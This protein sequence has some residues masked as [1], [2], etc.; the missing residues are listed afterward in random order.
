[1]LDLTEAVRQ[2]RE[3]VGGDAAAVPPGLPG[4]LPATAAAT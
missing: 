3:V 2:Y 4:P 1:M